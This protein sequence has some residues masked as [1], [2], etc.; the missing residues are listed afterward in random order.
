[1]S[2]SARARLARRPA[3]G[4]EAERVANTDLVPSSR[5]EQLDVI[6]GVAILG[7]LATHTNY[8]LV[9]RL[10]SHALNHWRPLTDLLDAGG[11]GVELF[12]FLSGWL[13]SRI[14]IE[15]RYSARSYRARRIARL[16]PLW[17]VF[18]VAGLVE[19]K[20]AGVHDLRFGS[21]SA[22]LGPG[23]S[24]FHTGWPWPIALLA[25]A[26]FLGWLSPVLYNGAVLGGWSIQVEVGHYLLFPLFRRNPFRNAGILV[27][28]GYASYGICRGLVHFWGSEPVIGWFASSWIR[29]GLYGTFPYF[30]AGACLR[31]MASGREKWD[32]P[33]VRA[34][35]SARRRWLPSVAVLLAVAFIVPLPY[36]RS[37]VAPI[38]LAVLLIASLAIGKFGRLGRA[39]SR[40]GYFSYFIYFCHFFI[41]QLLSPALDRLAIDAV[42]RSSGLLYP[43]AIG[44]GF[45][46]V[47]AICA[48]LAPLSMRFIER[49]AMRFSRRFD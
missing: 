37:F 49:P 45:V 20:I 17:L 12:F 42:G 1:V 7:V 26:V 13:L 38:A 6:R 14:Y 10:P 32:L 19:Y 39:F 16:W 31:A 48:L 11:Y 43:L 23:G 21:L 33:A 9:P 4:G 47:L 5:Q 8:Y 22:T 28:A 3:M 27:A 40:L 18:L 44:L 2:V 25:S 36:G 46:A 41:L 15:G 29:L 34:E 30:A 24:L 35:L